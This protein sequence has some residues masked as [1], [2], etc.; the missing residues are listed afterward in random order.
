MKD[1]IQVL[2]LLLE[3]I[4]KLDKRESYQRGGK[5]NGKVNN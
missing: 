4:I 1:N 2:K 5:K 3:S